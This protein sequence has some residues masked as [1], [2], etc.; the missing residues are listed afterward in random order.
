MSRNLLMIHLESLNIIN[1][2]VNRELFPNLY[3]WEKQ[4]LSFSRYY[5]TATST[6]M[7]I[8]DMAYGDTD[9]HET[10]GGIKWRFEE[11]IAQKSLWDEL[12]DNG[13][14]SRILLYPVYVGED[15]KWADKNHYFGEKVGIEE[16]GSYDSVIAEI[17][18]AL[19][20]EKPFSIYLCSYFTNLSYMK[21]CDG[22]KD[23]EGAALWQY[24]YQQLDE[25]I[26]EIMH[27]VEKTNHLKDTTIVFVGD[28]GD[29][30]F[31]HGCYGGLSHAIEP[32]ES[33][34][35]TPFF[36]YDNRLEKGVNN[37][38]T[39]TVDIK[40]I[41]LGF[42]RH[43]ETRIEIDEYKTDREYVYSRNL[44]AYQ[45]VRSGNFEKGYS[46]TDG[47]YLLLAGSQGIGMYNTIMDPQSQCNLLDILGMSPEQK[48][49]LPAN[50]RFHYPAIYN[51]KSYEIIER[52]YIKLKDALKQFVLDKY[53][54]AEC[55]HRLFEIDFDT[56]RPYRTGDKYRGSLEN[57][58]G[59]FGTGVFTKYF[60]NKRIII[61][62]A[63][64]YGKFCFKWI[65]NDCSIIAWLD[66]QYIEKKEC[67]GVKIE[68]PEHVLNYS[69]DFI[70]VA[71]LDSLA[72]QEVIGDLLDLG[73][74]ANSII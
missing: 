19:T 27:I 54:K 29:D 49:S 15:T 8:S 14:D 65:K 45:L 4:S 72:R 58:N 21:S 22:A 44:Y 62:G 16:F 63:G 55:A 51:N 30:L 59:T 33:L 56:I 36:I 43:D 47:Q 3:K 60:Y 41:M 53:I 46:I 23:L 25:Y 73:I 64:E 74:E 7:V 11:P 32:F 1:Y 61:Y 50:Y 31:Q 67:F 40:D 34:I 9:H 71:I 52:E 69:Y 68:P 5:S 12:L 20:G 24:C 42:L 17:Q 13:Y 37:S 57:Y 2:R 35:H 18:K 10:C 66:R 26:N 6:Y 39:S 38:L 70:F 48:W 28:H